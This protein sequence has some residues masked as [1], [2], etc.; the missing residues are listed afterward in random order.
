MI[1]D[2][3]LDLNG[4]REDANLELDLQHGDP[5]TLERPT[6]GVIL[7]NLLS[8]AF[9]YRDERKGKCVIKVKSRDDKNLIRITV[10]DNGTGIAPANRQLVFK[11]F[12]R[13]DERSGDGL[14]LALVKK[15]IDRL[16]GTITLSSVEGEGAAF[17]FTL[18][19]A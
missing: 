16:G 2:I 19:K 12:K 5:V 9:R 11:M 3:W 14:G 18:P 13:I 8:N 17:T 4:P 15:Q 10:S 1:H 7:D 6:L